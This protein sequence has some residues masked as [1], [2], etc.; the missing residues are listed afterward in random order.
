MARAKST[1]EQGRSHEQAMTD[2]LR[3]DDA[4]RSRSSGASWSDN[5]DVVSNRIAMECESTNAKS[6]TLKLGFWEE[7]VSKSTHTRMP[8]LGIEF[9]DP[10][11]NKTVRLVVMSSDDFAMLLEDDGEIS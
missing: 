9:R 10:D 4:R 3:F 8:A 11:K 1:S 5:I 7:V 2:L 6:Y